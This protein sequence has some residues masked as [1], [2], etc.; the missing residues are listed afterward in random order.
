MFIVTGASFGAIHERNAINAAMPVVPRDR[1]PEDFED[2]DKMDIDLATGIIRNI[3]RSVEIQAVPFTG[4][5]LENHRRGGLLG[6][7]P[8]A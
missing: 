8:W 4:I 5:R 2:G 3:T 1:S 6:A 7:E